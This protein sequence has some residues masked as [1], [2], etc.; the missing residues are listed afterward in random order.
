MG[1]R[2]WS[3]RLGV[4]AVVV[5][6]APLG[7]SSGGSSSGGDQGADAAASPD[8]STADIGHEQT[9]AAPGDTPDSG[10]AD[11]G[12]DAQ[13]D[14]SEGATTLSE[15]YPGDDGI[16]DDPAVIFFDDFEQGWGRWDAPQA[17]TQYLTMQ[18]DASIAHSGSG[19]LK[20]TVTTQD[21]Q[22]DQYI[23]SNARVSFDQVDEVYWRFYA[24][25]PNIAPNPH[26]WVRVSAGTDD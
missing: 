2:A 23:S 25:F 21:L 7:C 16:A 26:H 18:T 11:S 10:A 1:E 8:T 14:A 3:W 6:L 19:Y 15:R 12:D 5:V 9:D 24:R 4:L 13:A 17:D 22:N 20:S